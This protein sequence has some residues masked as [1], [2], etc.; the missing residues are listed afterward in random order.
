MAYF[1][2]YDINMGLEGLSFFHKVWASEEET[3]QQ[4]VSFQYA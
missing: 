4:Y 2:I 3:E 1:I